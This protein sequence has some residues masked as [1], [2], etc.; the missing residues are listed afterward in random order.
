[1]QGVG[2][3]KAGTAECGIAT[4]DGCCHHADDGQGTT[5]ETEPT[6]ADLLHDSGCGEVLNQ[7]L[8]AVALR[9]EGVDRVGIDDLAP[10]AIIEEIHGDGGPNQGNDALGNHGAVEDAAAH[11]LTLDAARHKW[12][13]RAVE[14]A[15]GTACNGQ[16]QAG[17]QRVLRHIGGN[18]QQRL[19]LR[20]THV[21]PYLR[22]RRHL[23][24][25][26]H[27]QCHSHEQHSEGKERIDAADNLINRK[28]GG[29]DVI[30]E[31]GDDPTHGAPAKGVEHQSRTID[32]HH[33]DHHQQEYGEH[34]HDALSVQAEVVADELR[35]V[36][37]IVA[38]AQHAGEIIVHRTGEDAAEDNPQISRR[39]V[40]GTHD[41]T[42]DR[43]STGD[44]KE[45]DH[46]HFPRRHGDVVDAI[47]IGNSRR[48]TVVRLEDA[49][50]ELAIKQVAQ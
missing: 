32:E 23:N 30:N 47:G 43:A 35:Q 42:K 4:G 19:R 31:D 18:A 50:N 2:N 15:D 24:E 29:E 21:V 12:T 9:Q 5:E 34:E 8:T 33:A 26:H 25:Q 7:R 38:H 14:T 11:A 46:I 27:H 17:E 40:P 3:D 44:V 13:L 45:L 20:G 48:R 10:A 1:M 16:E 36:A 37:A 41:G 49:L 28:K 6:G 39:T 22:Q